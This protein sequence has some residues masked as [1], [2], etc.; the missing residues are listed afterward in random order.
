MASVSTVSYHSS[1]AILS[2]L[3]QSPSATSGLYNDVMYRE[4]SRGDFNRDTGSV[5]PKSAYRQVVT[6]R[7]PEEI[8]TGRDPRGYVSVSGHRSIGDGVDGYGNDDG[9]DDDDDVSGYETDLDIENGKF[10]ASDIQVNGKF[11]TRDIRVNTVT[12]WYVCGETFCLWYIRRVDTL[13]V[14]KTTRTR[15]LY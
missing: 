1:T 3:A 9:F 2:P 13:F 7:K 11:I 5:S 12:P 14:H 6:F 4:T 10:I 8:T 15:L